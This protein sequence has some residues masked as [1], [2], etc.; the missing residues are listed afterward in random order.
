MIPWECA[1]TAPVTPVPVDGRVV[2]IATEH[3]EDAEMINGNVLP[4]RPVR[5]FPLMAGLMAH[6]YH[7]CGCIAGIMLPYSQ[8]IHAQ[9]WIAKT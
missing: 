7:G 5:P 2:V 3:T 1:A 4:V 8:S 6:W 9:L